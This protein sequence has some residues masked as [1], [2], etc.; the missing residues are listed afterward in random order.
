MQ[1]LDVDALLDDLL[2]ALSHTAELVIADGIELL[3]RD[4]RSLR[5]EVV[6]RHRLIGVGD[7]GN[8][9]RIGRVIDQHLRVATQLG[10]VNRIV[11]YILVI[12]SDRSKPAEVLKRLSEL[13]EDDARPYLLIDA[14]S[15][16]VTAGD[17][18]SHSQSDDVKCDG[19]RPQ[20]ESQE[21]RDTRADDD[22]EED[23]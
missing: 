11:V 23:H 20:G 2:V 9:E 19:T 13:L 8:I 22:I 1:R 5:L 10:E 3:V 17:E 15:G 14:R 6:K 18:G 12:I 21:R 7:V 4:G 16:N